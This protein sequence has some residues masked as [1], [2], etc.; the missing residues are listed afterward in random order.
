MPRIL[1]ISSNIAM[2]IVWGLKRGCP[3]EMNYITYIS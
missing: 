1:T 2:V 3:S